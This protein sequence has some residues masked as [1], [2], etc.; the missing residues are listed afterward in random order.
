MRIA[1]NILQVLK[2]RRP[3]SAPELLGA[4]QGKR[5]SLNK[6]TVYRALE[7]LA[8]DG[9]LSTV[10]F[11]D[12]VRRY[13]LGD[14]HHHHVVCTSCGTVADVEIDEDLER[15]ERA[16]AK[17]TGFMIRRHALE[18]FGLCPNCR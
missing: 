1:E 17:K 14:T 12:G 2:N 7:A 5:K 3:W 13:E 10:E 9:R 6:T 16:A 8:A 11:G 18:F 15:Q 4:L